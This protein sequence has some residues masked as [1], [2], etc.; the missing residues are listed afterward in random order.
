MPQG[1][2]SKHWCFTINNPIPLD[3]IDI[4]LVD[5]IVLGNEICPTTGTPHIQGYIIFKTKKRLTQTS[6]ILPRARLAIKYEDS[7]PKQASDYCK[8]DGNFLEYGV[9]PI[10]NSSHNIWEAAKQSAIEGNFDEI[11]ANML[12]RYYHNFK[13]LHQDNPQIPKNLEKLD[14]VWII[15][16]TGYGKSWYA[17]HKWPDHYD[18]PPNKWYVGYKG[19]TT[20]LLDDFGPKQCYYLGWYIKRWADVYP[21]PIETKGGGKDIRP[22]HIIIT[23][24]YTIEQCFEEDQLIIQA[25]KRR[26]RVKYMKHW[27]TGQRSEPLYKKQITYNKKERLF[28]S[29]WNTNVLTPRTFNKTSF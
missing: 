27:K 16:P 17:R 19:Q 3:A 4:F 20:L 23:S 11:P 13:R 29:Q 7:T 14:N 2:Q 6:K 24:N 9:L 26:F 12:I 10:G 1:K 28:S 5:Y 18:K 22:K 21:F 25:I 8:K 15:A